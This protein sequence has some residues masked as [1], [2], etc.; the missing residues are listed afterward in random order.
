MPLIIPVAEDNEHFWG[1]NIHYAPPM[2]RAKI[3]DMLKKIVEDEKKSE[4]AKKAAVRSLTNSLM[5]NR[6]VKPLIK[7]YLKKQVKSRFVEV[8]T[9]HWEITIYLPLAKWSNNTTDNQ[10]FKD[11]R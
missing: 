8:E 1:I 10:V 6:F 9:K 11:Y 4:V 5:R 7:C 3:Y 2:F